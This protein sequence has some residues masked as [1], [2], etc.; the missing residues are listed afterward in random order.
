M[1]FY[2]CQAPFYG[3]LD[4]FIHAG[5]A[6]QSLKKKEILKV[7]SCF[8]LRVWKASQIASRLLTVV[9]WIFVKTC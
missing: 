2:L 8:L 9:S 3:I 6:G 1:T 5:E 4:K 7:L